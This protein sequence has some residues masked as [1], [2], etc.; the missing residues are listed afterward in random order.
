MKVRRQSVILD[1]VQREPVRNQE[2]LRRR[3][4]AEGFD[5]TQA[6]LSR[7]IRELGLVKGG[8]TAAYQTPALL[9]DV[10]ARFF[11]D[12]NRDLSDAIAAYVDYV[13]ERLADGAPL[14]AMTK[15]M[16]G[17]FHGKPGARL[18]RRH[19]SENATRKGAGISVL[20]DALAYIGSERAEAA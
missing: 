13:A 17:L 1:L 5:V 20:R 11:G 3:L 2:Q 8:E 12:A 14:N 15:H 6:T 7:D 4:R 16:L 10:D 18:F 19:L 9:L